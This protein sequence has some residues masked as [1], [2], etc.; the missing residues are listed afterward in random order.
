MVRTLTLPQGFEQFG[1]GFDPFFEMVEGF[2][3]KAQNTYPP[4]NVCRYDDNAYAIELAVAGFENEE[5]VVTLEDNVLTIDG[6]CCPAGD[7]VEFLHKGISSRDFTKK[8]T[9]SDD[10]EVMGSE[11]ENGLLIITLERIVPEEKKTRTIEIK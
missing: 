3:G 5:L 8:F 4:H 10:I 6:K 1:I 7:Q 2:T 11:L 9:L